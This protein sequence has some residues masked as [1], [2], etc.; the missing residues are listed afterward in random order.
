MRVV[1][2]P[3][4]LLHELELSGIQQLDPLPPVPRILGQLGPASPWRGRSRA[5]D[6]L[7]RKLSYPIG[8]Q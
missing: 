6:S 8:G 2:P 3:M 1:L 4:Q 7:E 5:A